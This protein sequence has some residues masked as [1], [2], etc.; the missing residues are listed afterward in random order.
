MHIRL[1]Q[2]LTG[3]NAL[4]IAIAGTSAVRGM[5]LPTTAAIRFDIGD[6]IIRAKFAAVCI[7]IANVANVDVVAPSADVSVATDALPQL[8]TLTVEVV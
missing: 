3:G 5:Y 8:G 6:G 1:V 2:S 7:Q 4:T